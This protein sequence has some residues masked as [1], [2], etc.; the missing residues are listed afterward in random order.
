MP[1][2]LKRS[3]RGLPPYNLRTLISAV[4]NSAANTASID[5]HKGIAHKLPDMSGVPGW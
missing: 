4:T 1:Q 5:C 2:S 3:H